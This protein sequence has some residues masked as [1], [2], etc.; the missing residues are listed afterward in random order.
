[1]LWSILITAIPERYHSV[2]PLLH[3]LLEKQ[4]VARMPDVELLYLMDNRRRPVGAK[5][6][7]MLAMAK[8]EYVSFID[9]DDEV[10]VD[11]VQKIYRAIVKARKSELAS[12]GING[13]NQDGSFKVNQID[14]ICFPQRATLNPAG[15]THE[16]TYSLKHWK[17]R[18]PEKRR[19]LAQA[20]KDGKPIL[21]TLDW[22]GPPAH[23]M[24]WRLDC[25]KDCR[26]PDQNYG[27]D[28]DFVDQAC[29]LAKNELVLNGAPL[30]YYKFSEE[31]TAT[32]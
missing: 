19:V 2:Q 15:V 1:M 21:N 13:R 23:T 11:Y 22:T 26:F 10:S 7:D 24:V 31:G 27:E 5:R 18:E 16:C 29:E 9:D 30:Y 6:N 17:D 32:R 4:A 12:A 28:V 8:G 20:M 14:V 3:N 25:I